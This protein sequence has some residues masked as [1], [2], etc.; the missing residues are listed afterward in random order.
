MGSLALSLALPEFDACRNERRSASGNLSPPT[1]Y[2]LAV[3]SP[4]T[5]PDDE[6]AEEMA[7]RRTPGC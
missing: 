2:R 1:C 3:G 6:H 5:I 4:F 7:K